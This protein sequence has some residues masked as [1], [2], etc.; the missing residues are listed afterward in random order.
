MNVFYIFNH[1]NP[2][3]EFCGVEMC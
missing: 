2:M 1:F 3:N